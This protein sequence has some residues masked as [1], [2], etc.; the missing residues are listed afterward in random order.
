MTPLMARLSDSVAPLVKTISRGAAPANSATRFRA[1]STAF[2][3][4]HPKPWLRLAALP[5]LAPKNGSMASS[6]RGSNGAVVLAAL[7]IASVLAAIGITMSWLR[8][9]KKPILQ[10]ARIIKSF[11]WRPALSRDGKLLAYCSSIG[12]G[13]QHIWVQQTAGGKAIPVT[14]GP[15]AEIAPDFSPDGTHIAFFSL[16]NG[17]GIYIAPT[18]PGEPR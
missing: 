16:R 18:L 4:S 2:S 5:K 9:P 8:Q 11:G 10:E 15:D 13:E 3:A 12:G 14:A 17:G 6:T 1:N 7:T